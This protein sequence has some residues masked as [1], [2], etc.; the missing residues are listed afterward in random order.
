MFE[1]S[2]PSHQSS[3]CKQQQQQKKEKKQGQ[4]VNFIK[5]PW[6]SKTLLQNKVK[7]EG[8]KNT[9]DD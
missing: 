6:E 3:G 7:S 9:L 8:E 4:V 2:Y 5:F 1:V